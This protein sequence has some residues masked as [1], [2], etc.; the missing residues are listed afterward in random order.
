MLPDVSIFTIGPSK[1]SNQPRIDNTRPENKYDWIAVEQV[2]CRY[3][4][5]HE[6]SPPMLHVDDP[7]A[8]HWDYYCEPGTGGELVS[9]RLK[10][11][12]LPMVAP[13]FSFLPAYINGHEYYFLVRES[14]ID[15]LDR[16]Q[17]DIMWSARDP[18]RVA[19]V[20]KYAFRTERLHDPLVFAIPEFSGRV[21]F[22][23]GAKRQVE[24]QQ[25]RGMQFTKVAPLQ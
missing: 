8:N 4:P 3:A 2:L 5:K 25:L 6:Y 22:T 17:S 13:C 20:R 16:A 10:E 15:C 19:L 14:A 1:V 9:R 21:F 12:L 24:V 18:S 7:S 11:V 23:E